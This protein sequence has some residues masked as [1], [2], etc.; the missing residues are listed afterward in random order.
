SAQI[1]AAKLQECFGGALEEQVE[2]G[3][4]IFLLAKHER[5]EFVRQREDIVKVRHGQ[6]FR[7][8]F[9]EPLR[10]DQGLTL[11]TVTVAARIVG[12]ALETARG[13]VLPMPAQSGG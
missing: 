13:A 1:I 5:V 3:T 9:F 8:T 6:Q 2:N 11:G 12:V 10:F 4:L 7:L